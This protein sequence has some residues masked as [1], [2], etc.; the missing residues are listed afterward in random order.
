MEKKLFEMYV[1]Q[2]GKKGVERIF[3]SRK[4][5]GFSK[6]IISKY[7]K[8]KKFVTIGYD[9]SDCLLICPF[10]SK[11]KLCLKI[12]NNNFVN[13]EKVLEYFRIDLVEEKRI[14]YFNDIQ[15]SDEYS[16]LI[17]NIKKQIKKKK[18]MLKHRWS[19]KH[20]RCIKCGTTE[21]IHKAKGLCSK[22]DGRER[23][24]ENKEMIR[25]FKRVL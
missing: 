2:R 19:I 23:R 16:G 5:I 13:I 17:I 9:K 10:E 14:Y 3:L 20:D 8:D 18:S 6:L 22:C 15:W 21:I 1:P 24:R 25:E 4:N 12:N 7:F 11:E